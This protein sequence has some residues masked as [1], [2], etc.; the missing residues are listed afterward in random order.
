MRK[1]FGCSVLIALVFLLASPIPSQARGG[2]VVFGA[3]IWLGPGYW[4]PGWWWGSP[5]YYA[6]PPVVMQPAPTYAQP[7]PPPQE[8]SY[9]Y[10]CQNPQGY[11][12]YV[13]Q[14]PH[15]W[16][17]VVPPATAPAP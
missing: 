2:H 5:Y 13:Q 16:M 14:C 1:I 8:P 11:Y 15:G 7:A 12:P 6:A 9:W 17:K 3:N 4:G 10:Y